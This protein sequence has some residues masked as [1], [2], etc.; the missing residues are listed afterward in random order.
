MSPKC[1]AWCKP[2]ASPHLVFSHQG[3]N[4]YFQTLEASLRTTSALVFNCDA[5]LKWNEVSKVYL[6]QCWAHRRW[7]INTHCP[8]HPPIA[9]ALGGLGAVADLGMGLA[10]LEGLRA[11]GWTLV[12]QREFME[13]CS[14][15]WRYTQRGEQGV[16]SALVLLGSLSEWIKR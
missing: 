9:P 2:F 8:P 3:R 4:Y 1:Q 12:H 11:Q 16:H 5:E 14:Y 15:S 7:S 10:G 6:A 13:P